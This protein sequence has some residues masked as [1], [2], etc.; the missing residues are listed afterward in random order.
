MP[1]HPRLRR[2]RHSPLTWV[3][4]AALIVLLLVSAASAGL[5]GLLIAA[6]LIGALTALY[7]LI[8]GRR[9][10]AEIPSRRVASI[11]LAAALITVVVGVT[12]APASVAAVAALI[13]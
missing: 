8:S 11:A 13:R 2:P 5:P 10:W 1:S 6:G 4:G 9:S 7:S 3:V 12:L